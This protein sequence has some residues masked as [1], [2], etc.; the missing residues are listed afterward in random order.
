MKTSFHPRAAF[1]AIG[2][3][4]L[5]VFAPSVQAAAPSDM[6]PTPLAEVPADSNTQAWG[7]LQ[8]DKAVSGSPLVIAGRTFTH[9][10]GTHAA[11]EIVYALEDGCETFTAWVGV[12]DHLKAHPDAKNASVVFQ[13]IGDGKTL[14]ESGVM[15]MGDAAKE[16]KV[17]LKGVAQLKLIVTDAGDGNS[18][19]H[20]D[21][22]DAAS[23]RRCRPQEDGLRLQLETLR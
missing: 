2:L 3:A 22:A 5:A 8:I 19:D 1:T 18:C 11:S 7:S 14:F 6:T 17:P 16:V 12:D 20:A 10:L 4:V 15:R 21:W 23:D 9:G 13:V